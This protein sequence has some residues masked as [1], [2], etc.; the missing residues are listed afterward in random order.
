MFSDWKTR[1]PHKV[2]DSDR[3]VEAIQDG[4]RVYLSGNCS[5]PKKL[6]DAL[7]RRAPK[8]HNVEIDQVL[9]VC[10][11]DYVSPAME[12][13]L[14]VNTMF[15]SE[16]IRQA[17]NDGRAD[18]TPCF[19]S[20]VPEL[21]RR[22]HLSLDAVLLHVSPPDSHGFVSLGVESGM[23]K[24]PASLAHLV[25]AEVNE[26]MPRVLGDTLLHISQ[27]D[28]LIPV[29]YELAEVSMGEPGEISLKIA[30]HIAPLIE[31]GATLQ[32]G[33]GEIPGAVLRH[34]VDKK[35]LGIHTE[36]I[37]DGMVDLAEAGVVTN[38]RKKIHRGKI[39]AGFLIGTRRL[40]DFV[41]DNPFV[42]LHPIEHVNDPFVIS[43]NDNVVAINSAIEVDLTGQVSADSIGTK[44]YSG[45][46]GQLDFMYGASRSKGGRPIIALPSTYLGKDGSLR[47]KIAPILT[48]GAGVTTTRNHVHTIVTEFG[49]AQLY[50][51]NIR[52]RIRALID[53]AHPEFREDLSR[54]ARD[55]YRV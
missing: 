47:T 12:G 36:L 34:L 27:I 5:V 33:I 54:Q 25:I 53:I 2:V 26:R 1:Y 7:V 22:G 31:D 46:G 40:F 20:E 44:L 38:A 14:R 35:D 19:L 4:Y 18:F 28:Y 41:D 8:V 50:G 39:I 9:T 6:L 30:E 49:A 21:Y 32:A 48:P 29:D 45:V 55:L 24:T 51:K 43:R 11:D 15:I 37:S 3:A 13:H 23:V 16:N 17:V 10:P 52:Q 42:E